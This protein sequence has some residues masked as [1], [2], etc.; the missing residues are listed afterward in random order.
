VV[1][2]GRISSAALLDWSSAD[3]EL[4]GGRSVG[5]LVGCGLKD[6]VDWIAVTDLMRRSGTPL[7][8][9]H[10]LRTTFRVECRDEVGTA[11]A[12]SRRT[13]NTQP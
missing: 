12:F 7:R 3:V 8:V 1:F 5:S 6:P 11:S 13:P 10:D 4:A 2:E 9:A